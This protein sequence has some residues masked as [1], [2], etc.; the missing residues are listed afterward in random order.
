MSVFLT[1]RDDGCCK[2]S[3]GSTLTRQ[4]VSISKTTQR[5]KSL[6]P[7]KWSWMKQADCSPLAEGF[8]LLQDGPPRPP[9]ASYSTIAFCFWHRISSCQPIQK[10]LENAC[11]EAI[12]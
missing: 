3:C 7:D 12:Q 8:E 5:Q 10:S 2:A 1:A 9:R 4:M 11:A 6:H